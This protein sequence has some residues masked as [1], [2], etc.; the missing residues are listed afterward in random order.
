MDRDLIRSLSQGNRLP[1]KQNILLTGGIGS[2]N[3]FLAC[4]LGHNACR[5][6]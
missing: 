3:T 4:A 5:Q 1:L 2:G 6:V